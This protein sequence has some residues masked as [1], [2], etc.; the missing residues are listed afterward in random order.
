[1]EKEIFSSI[2]LQVMLIL[3]TP[4]YLCL[5]FLGLYSYKQIIFIPP[6]FYLLKSKG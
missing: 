3:Y 4:I 5:I 6:C 1:M 2:S